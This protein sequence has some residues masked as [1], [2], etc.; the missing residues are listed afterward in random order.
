[1]NTNGDDDVL[2]AGA[3]PIDDSETPDVPVIPEDDDGEFQQ[4]PTGLVETGDEEETAEETEEE[5]EEETTEET[6]EETTEET[7]EETTEETEEETAD[8]EETS[9][10]EEAPA[11]T[12]ED[13]APK[14]EPFIPKHRLDQ[15]AR[16]RRSLEAE[17][18]ELRKAAAK[19]AAPAPVP[20]IDM[21]ALK[22]DRAKVFEL[23]LDGK[24]AEAS[25][26]QQSIDERIIAASQ[27][28]E[29][30]V[31]GEISA[32]EMQVAFN[33][34]VDKMEEAYP[35]LNPDNADI[36]DADLTD[37]IVA[38]RDAY[39]ARNYTPADALEQAVDDMVRAYRPEVLSEA[40]PA[41]ETPAPRTPKPR[42][43]KKQTARI[44]KEPPNIGKA[45][46]AEVEDGA[47]DIFSMS[48]EDFDKLS[49]KELAQ[50]R[51]DF[52]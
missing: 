29:V 45:K 19:A 32:R 39:Q 27:P 8:E 25:E 15:E 40:A 12:E 20:A 35:F 21:D 23:V 36:Y 28:K 11:E 10:D 44:N 17:N 2:F 52:G 13:S 49:E 7:E 33:S 6:E 48:E 42:D 26:L 47:I 3:D 9:E 31:S 1:M 4:D 16:K 14:K 34:T 22:V 41:A 46:A 37:R 30:D 24:T 50:L 51:G 43:V 5:T 38:V 18:A